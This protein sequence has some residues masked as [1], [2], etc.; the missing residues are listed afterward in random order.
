MNVSK[1]GSEFKVTRVSKFGKI[2]VIVEAN[3]PIDQAITY[4]NEKINQLFSIGIENK[5]D[6]P[7]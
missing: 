7:A 6:V 2:T 3:E 1:N 5:S 4:F